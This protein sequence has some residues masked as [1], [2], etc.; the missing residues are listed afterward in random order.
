MTW[1][2]TPPTPGLVYIAVAF[3]YNILL[4]AI[5]IARIICI[6]RGLRSI[7]RS[8]ASRGIW[9]FVVGVVLE[10]AAFYAAVAIITI[11]AV[12]IGTSLQAAILPLL[13]Q[14]QVR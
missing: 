5:M 14:M 13:G 8:R 12:A 11:V 6:S 7:W 3:A 4:P 10:S 2:S 1:T 9:A